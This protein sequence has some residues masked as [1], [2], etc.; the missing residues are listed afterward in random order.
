MRVIQVR[1]TSGQ[2]PVGQLA[3]AVIA[4][5]TELPAAVARLDVG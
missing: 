5:L 1:T 3:D 2:P 4:S